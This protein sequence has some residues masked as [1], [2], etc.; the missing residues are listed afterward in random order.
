MYEYSEKDVGP[1]WRDI[2]TPL[3]ER[4]KREGVRIN[5]IKEK[6]GGLRFYV[7]AVSTDF[8][9][10]IDAAERKSTETCD[11]CGKPASTR[12]EEW[13]IKTRCDECVDKKW[14]RTS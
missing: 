6:F 11:V 3:I 8:R 4:A 14:E 13:W 12:N 9:A 5:Q 2:V 7:G 1:G 10:E